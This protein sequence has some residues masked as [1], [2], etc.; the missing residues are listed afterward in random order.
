M[1]PIKPEFWN[2]ALEEDYYSRVKLSSFRVLHTPVGNKYLLDP[3][4]YV[5]LLLFT[6][7]SLLYLLLLFF[8]FVFLV[9][10]N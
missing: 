2:R 7:I 1:T 8:C 10:E 3:K 6:Q 4:Y 9:P 5:N